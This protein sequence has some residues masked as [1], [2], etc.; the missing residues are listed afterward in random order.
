M[1]GAN[2]VV[3]FSDLLRVEVLHAL[4]RIGSAPEYLTGSV[5][6]RHRLQHWGQREAVRDEWFRFGLREFE[7]L[8]DEFYRVDEIALTP[9]ILNTCATLMARYNLKSN[10]A[11]HLATAR[12]VGVAQIVTLDR[13]FAAVSE[14]AVLL[15]QL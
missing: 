5:R 8:L 11:V 7:A 3:C 6:R 2:N 12:A 4:R 9:S 1:F 13:D 14:P 10:D 15:L